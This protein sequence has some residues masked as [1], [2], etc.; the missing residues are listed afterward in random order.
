[1]CL[2]VGWTAFQDVKKIRTWDTGFVTLMTV[3]LGIIAVHHQVN[4]DILKDSQ[5]PGKNSF[6]YLIKKNT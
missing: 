5:Y 2:P 3:V 4:V 6:F 1:M